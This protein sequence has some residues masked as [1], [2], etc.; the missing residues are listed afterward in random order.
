MDTH[1]KEVKVVM[2]VCLQDMPEV[3]TKAE[4]ADAISKLFYENPETFGLLTDENIVNVREYTI[5][6][7]KGPNDE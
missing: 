6:S 2:Y 4:I 7:T 3:K 1:I 5:R